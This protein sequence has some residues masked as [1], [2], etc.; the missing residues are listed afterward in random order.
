MV[1]RS[2]YKG[3]RMGDFMEITEEG[4]R[5]WLNGPLGRELTVYDVVDSTNNAARLLAKNGAP[6][7]AA[8]LALCQTAGKGRLGRGFFSPAGAGVYLSVI[9]RPNC[10]PE[11]SLALTS[12][13]AVAVCRAIKTVCGLETK[14]KWVNDIYWG[15]RKLCGILAESV[16]GNAG[17]DYVVLGV[18]VN[19][20]RAAFPPELSDVAVSLEEAG[21]RL[22]DQ[23]RLAAAILNELG[24]CEN[25]DFLDE[26]RARS[27]VLGRQV[28]VI[29][30]TRS[31]EAEA[32]DLD[33]RG[34]LRVVTAEGETIMLS[35]GEIS[36]RG[37]FT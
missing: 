3:M 29:Q 11:Q 9:L 4:I 2:L 10:S 5:K 8:V 34:H 13:A 31:Y 22:V 7:G 30:G 26:Y 14:I 35:S 17:I 25:M 1:Y 32:V 33:Q 18:G 12:A 20:L 37:D 15:G 28:R 24:R 27:C 23:N 6:H 19:V 36:L 16:L 21:A